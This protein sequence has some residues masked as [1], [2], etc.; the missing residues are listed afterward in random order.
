MAF[1]AKQGGR[2]TSLDLLAGPCDASRDAIAHLCC[3]VVLLAP[4]QL[5]VHENHQVLLHR[6]VSS[7]S[8]PTCA[9]II[10]SQLQE[11]VFLLVELKIS[12]LVRL[13]R[14]LTISYFFL[15]NLRFLFSHFS[16]V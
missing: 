4:G 11:F 12:F 16:H 5:I 15:L 8:T 9:R 1:N 14:K 7:Q 10:P 3:G 6:T 2:I 13:N